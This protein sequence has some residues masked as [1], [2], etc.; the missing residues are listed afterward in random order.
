METLLDEA[1]KVIRSE[2]AALEALEGSL[3]DSFCRAV[4]L[5]HAAQ[6]RVVVTGVGKSGLIARKIAATMASTGTPAFFIHAAEALHG[7]LGM[8]TPEDVVLMI[9]HSGE[10]AELL[11]M[12][13]GLEKIG[14]AMIAIVG[15]CGSRIGGSCTVEIPTGVC[16]EA[17]H[18]NLAPTN[19]TTAALVLGDALAL[20]LS[21]EKEFTRE[22]FAR[23]H[24]GGSL[25][26]QLAGQKG[27]EDVD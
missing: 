25:G 18:L 27:D 26:R 8:V 10:T 17:D 13:R 5:I 23:C 2:R 15:R 12:Q 11:A 3:D 7:D 20:V 24:P 9:T 14:V 19:S 6:G 22:D 21:R 16:A 4:H 1:R